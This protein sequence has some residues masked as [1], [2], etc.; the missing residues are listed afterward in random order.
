VVC[1]E[2]FIRT[3]GSRKDPNAIKVMWKERDYS[4]SASFEK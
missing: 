3:K 1:L 4:S 2:V